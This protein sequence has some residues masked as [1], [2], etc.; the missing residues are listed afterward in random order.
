MASFRV[1]VTQKAVFAARNANKIKFDY[2][3]F[4]VTPAPPLLLKKGRGYLLKTYIHVY[5]YEIMAAEV[6]CLKFN[7]I[8]C[9]WTKHDM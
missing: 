8:I 3:E 7:L 9:I 6:G 1:S 4:N 2:V 5:A